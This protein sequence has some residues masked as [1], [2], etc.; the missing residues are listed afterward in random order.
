[1]I[2]LHSPVA[3]SDLREVSLIIQVQYFI[4]FN[5]LK[6]SFLSVI[7]NSFLLK[8]ECM[9][10]SRNWLNAGVFGAV[11]DQYY[12]LKKWGKWLLSGYSIRVAK[13]I[14]YKTNICI[15]RQIIL[16]FLLTLMERYSLNIFFFFRKSRV[17]FL[18][19]Y[20]GELQNIFS[21]ARVP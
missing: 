11:L 1:M 20:S 3:S 6:N 14:Q 21:P 16:G 13:F 9:K 8:K 18:V 10:M 4:W 15:F 2:S 17:A 19:P 7:D 5:C 12:W